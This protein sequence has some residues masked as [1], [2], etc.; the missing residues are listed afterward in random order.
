MLVR[1]YQ[2][3]RRGVPS[4]S[5]DSFAESA[6]QDSQSFFSSQSQE[7]QLN[8]LP[9]SQNSDWSLVGSD[10]PEAMLERPRSFHCNANPP[11]GLF[12]PES[13][14]LH[15]S[16]SEPDAFRGFLSQP[17]RSSLRPPGPSRTRT[18][19]NRAEPRRRSA[20][21]WRSQMDGGDDSSGFLNHVKMKKGGKGSQSKGSQGQGRKQ[22]RRGKAEGE[23]QEAEVET[24]GQRRPGNG[25]GK[26]DS[27]R[28]SDAE[29]DEL[30]ELEA[31]F[32]SPV[33]RNTLLTQKHSSSLMHAAGT[34]AA[35][36]VAAA[37]AATAAAAA[38]AAGASVLESQ[39]LYSQD[40]D[41]PGPRG[42]SFMEPEESDFR[43]PRGTS[44]MEAQE[45]GEMM[46]SL[47]EA[48][49]ALD[50]LKLRQ[51][52][53]VQRSAATSLA[54]I[55]SAVD[56]RRLLRSQG[57]VGWL[58]KQIMDAL[59]LL[60]ITDHPLALAAA[61][62]FFFVSSDDVES[63]FPD[64]SHALSFLLAL[65]KH[66]SAAVPPPV[67]PSPRPAHAS[68]ASCGKSPPSRV[69]FP[70]RECPVKGMER[71]E[72]EAAVAAETAPDNTLPPFSSSGPGRHQLMRV[73]LK[74]E[75][76]RLGGLHLVAAVA[77]RHM[78]QFPSLSSSTHEPHA[79]G[80][81]AKEAEREAWGDAKR[82]RLGSKEHPCGFEK[83]H[84]LQQKHKRMGGTEATAAANEGLTH[85]GRISTGVDV[86]TS[87]LGVLEHVT[88]MSRDNQDY[89]IRLLLPTDTLPGAKRRKL[90]GCHTA[91]PAA[92]PLMA[93]AASSRA[94][95]E[96]KGGSSSERPFLALLL[97]CLE[98][99]A[100]GG[101]I[102]TS[103]GKESAS[104]SETDSEG[105][106]E[107]AAGGAVRA[108]GGGVVILGDDVPLDLGWEEGSEEG[109][110]ERGEGEKGSG[111]NGGERVCG[112]AA[113]GKSGGGRRGVQAGGKERASAAPFSFDPWGE[114]GT[115]RVAGKIVGKIAV[116]AGAGKIAVRAGAGKSSG[117]D[118]GPQGKV[119]FNAGA[120]RSAVKQFEQ[121]QEQ[122][123]MLGEAVEGGYDEEEE[124]SRH[125]ENGA[126]PME[127]RHSNGGVVLGEDVPA[128]EEE[129]EEEDGKEGEFG[130]R[131]ARSGAV[132]R[133]GGVVLGE[134]VGEEQEGSDDGDSEESGLSGRERH[135]R[136]C[137]AIKS[138]SGVRE[139]GDGGLGRSEGVG[140][141]PYEFL[142]D[143]Q[144][145]EE[146]LLGEELLVGG[147]WGGVR[148]GGGCGE[149]QGGVCGWG[150]RL[151]EEVEGGS[152]GNDGEG[153]E[154]CRQACVGDHT[155][156]AMGMMMAN[157]KAMAVARRGLQKG[158]ERWQGR[159]GLLWWRLWLR[160]AAPTSAG[161]MP[162]LLLL[163]PGVTLQESQ[164]W[165]QLRR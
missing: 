95:G 13:E 126:L 140:K 66:H 30:R 80:L 57:W 37:T 72:A 56:R 25:K 67:S 5:D 43:G 107:D 78:L 84:H 113:K 150:L 117:A 19:P 136:A 146:L 85:N 139:R 110:V 20:A 38:S 1:T 7:F 45:S 147:E 161:S 87:C 60:P 134:A 11:G 112:V 106:E 108:G 4:G 55:C 28:E 130:T 154:L 96:G 10:D 121:K 164:L 92:V 90:S 145:E 73:G 151:G 94:F 63:D 135:R 101:G 132:G 88:F 93:A 123:V 77:A 79:G 71:R 109:E 83:K 49:F 18:E 31:L 163:R 48:M 70:W 105:E 41:L 14:P 115:G 155:R 12:S 81:G 97:E 46:A 149:G 119:A 44:L 34:A 128:A 127:V 40:S 153:G 69:G 39:E 42:S 50:G 165:Q 29:E 82:R 26:Q 116:R 9:S 8:G 6:S 152:R 15:H 65:L 104:T 91:S 99:L 111:Q 22:G 35:A 114:E 54:S 159:T 124:G 3:K 100:G 32:K 133:G 59:L 64:P 74:D 27:E 76:R 137:S 51:P 118:K 23:S 86:A 52:I 24:L 158:A 16:C 142:M 156:K 21:S 68:A 75:M 89:L 143:S 162:S 122:A 53:R 125:G 36:A 144:V 129:D 157:A 131:K 102:P 103:K 61:A 141:D 62:S 148:G 120:R 58:I 2:R 47:D 98:G 160:P 17:T 33:H 138:G